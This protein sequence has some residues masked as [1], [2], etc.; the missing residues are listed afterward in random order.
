MVRSALRAFPLL[1]AAALAAQETPPRAQ[2]SPPKAPEPPSFATLVETF[3]ASDQTDVALRDRAAAA[4]LADT[5]RALPWL[6]ERLRTLAVGDATAR[7]KALRLLAADVVLGFVDQKHRSGVVYRGQ[8]AQLAA[9]QPFAAAQLFEWLLRTPD[10][11]PDTKRVTFVPA[12]ADLQPAAPEAS[13]LLGV[14]EL[15]ENVDGE[16]EDLRLALSC[17]LWQWGRK[18]FVEQRVTQ[19][20]QDST[21]GDAEV[22]VPALRQLSDLWYRVREYRRAASTHAVMAAL[23]SRTK[24]ELLPTDWYWGACY[25]ALSGRRD[26]AFADLSRCANLQASKDV[27]PVRKLPRALFETDPEIASLRDDPRFLPIL[28]RAFPTPVEG[29]KG[30]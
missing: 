30:R 16:P 5:E 8:Y 28:Q 29:E 10:W 24:A 1:L 22:R 11:L 3:L 17:L 7:G 12:L 21:E 27:D 23:A 25:N 6:G 14:T 4:V 2:E 9:L 19:L 20:Q 13:I 26:E 15:V 18:Q